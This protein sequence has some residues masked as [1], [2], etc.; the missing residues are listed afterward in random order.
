MS[1]LGDELQRVDEALAAFPEDVAAYPGGM[2]MRESLERHR[3]A[4]LRAAVDAE[5][6][7][8]LA[9]PARRG[10]GGELKLVAGVL[11]ALQDSLSSIAQTLSGRPTARGMIPGAVV[12]SV[13][14]RVASASPGSLAMSLEPAYPETQ[15]PLFEDGE[16]STLDLSV[17][18]LVDVL[19]RAD[20][21]PDEV[22]ESLAGLG[23]RAAVHIQAFAKTLA[24]ASADVS[25]RWRSPRRS[26]AVTLAS[27]SAE[28]LRGVIAAVE[29]VERVATFT[30]RLVGG[31]LIRATFE[32]ELDDE[33]IIRGPA[34]PGVLGD[35]EELFGRVC[36]ATVVTREL[37][38]HSGE[39]REAHRL[40][41]LVP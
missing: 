10:T 21:A 19:E 2:L 25:L 27:A 40:T 13:E 14:L 34:D 12:E 30:G 29:E 18:R 39:T 15:V 9:R 20:L 1:Q 17:G 24:D 38:L 35:L 5:L 28:R 7:L 11:A 36:A 33:S 3:V 31:S 16:E 23:P 22:L 6:D 32:L 26:A 41:K 4:L 37:R 8:T